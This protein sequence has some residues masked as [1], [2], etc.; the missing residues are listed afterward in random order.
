MKSFADAI[1][2][3][4]AA[5]YTELN[6]EEKLAQDIVLKALD[7]S[8]LKA[9]VTIKGGVVMA[10]IT[11]D[12]RRTTMDL[13]IDFIHYP[14]TDDGIEQ[15]VAKLNCVL[16]VTIKRVG[17]IQDLKHQDY[18]GKRVI[19]SLTDDE[20]GSLQYK[21]D[22]GVHTSGV[23]QQE[24]SFD[25]QK[26][27]LG[28]AKLLTNRKEQVFVEKLKSLLRLGAISSRG[29]DVYDMA[30]LVDSVD[31]EE[32]RRQIDVCIFQ[33]AKML[34]DSLDDILRRLRRT[35]DD[36]GFMSMLANRRMNWLG[37]APKEA[38]AKVL[39]FIEALSW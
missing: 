38:I 13:D 16:G 37:L 2:K 9:N 11:G 14:L 32:L 10:A 17:D 28:E 4:Q 21:L 36:R 6:V 24:L 15:M 29:K 33:D 34:E 3:L 7:G 19:L 31:K 26:V 8:G 20:G 30:Y 1:V 12:I 18:H 35:F 5:G 25:L 23:E 39:E 27:E 22:I